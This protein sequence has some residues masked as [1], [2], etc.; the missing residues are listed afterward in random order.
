MQDKKNYEIVIIGAGV[1]GIAA[2]RAAY[3]EGCH[4]ILMIDARKK[5][6]GILCQCTHRGFGLEL[7]G[8]EYVERLLDGFPEEIG[9]WLDTTVLSV[10]E[11]KNIV[12]SGSGTGIQKIAF[13]QLILAAGC[14]EIPLGFLPIA[15]TRPEGIYTAGQ[16]QEMV[17]NCGILPEEPVVI[18]GSG[19]L[20]LIMAQQLT[21]KG[22]FVA[23]VI[24]QRDT[25]GGFT[26]NQNCI[27]SGKVPLFCSS[28]ITELYG[29][30][31]LR[32]VKIQNK[33]TKEETQIPCRSLLVAAG[34]RPDRSLLDDF[35][36]PYPEWIHLCGNCK[37]VHPMVD[38]VVKE[39]REA[40]ISAYKGKKYD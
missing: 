20:G 18:L 9:I 10:T 33:D 2:A 15:G 21:E 7:T 4:S 27:R 31:R 35:G 12:V 30:K 5:M 23:A 40:G 29:A 24:E 36:Y 34:L 1:A 22:V 26:R 13:E 25:C 19:D 28:T 11:E 38:A 8:P 32:A 3:E 6:G 39:G 14:L 17:N 37:K 16:M